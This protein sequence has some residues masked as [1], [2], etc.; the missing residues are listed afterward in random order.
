MNWGLE[1][2]I[3]AIVLLGT[4]AVLVAVTRRYVSHGATQIAIIAIVVLAT[5]AIWAQL[6]VGLVG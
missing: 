3:A 6:A 1:D 2:I 4:A 5:L